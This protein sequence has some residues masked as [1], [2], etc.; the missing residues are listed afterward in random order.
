MRGKKRKWREGEKMEREEFSRSPFPLSLHFLLLSPFSLHFLILS[1]FPRSPAARLPQ[2]VREAPSKDFRCSTAVL[3]NLLIF[4]EKYL[5]QSV[6]LL[7]GG[8]RGG[9][10]TLFGRMPFEQAVSLPGA[11]LTACSGYIHT[12]TNIHCRIFW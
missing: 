6:R 3:K 1:P 9:V 8:G 2:V 5:L 12:Y 10:E 11:S 7:E 4:G